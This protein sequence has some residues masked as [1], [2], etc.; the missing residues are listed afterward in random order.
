MK[1]VNLVV[2]AQGFI[3]VPDSFLPSFEAQLSERDERLDSVKRH[4]AQSVIDLVQDLQAHGATDPSIFEGF[5]FSFR[6]PQISSEFDLLKITASHVVNIELKIEDVG[7]ERIEHQLA[8]NR[9]Y[10]APLERTT[11]TFTYV[12]N[13]GTLFELQDNGTFEQASMGRLATLLAS[14][15]E[16]YLDRVEDLFKA[17]NYLV[18]PLNDTDRFLEGSYF[19]TN[20]QEQIKAS[21]VTAC[22]SAR[23]GEPVVYL[24]YGSTGT[25]KSLLLYDL[26]RSLSMPRQ[27]GVIH[28]GVL[29]GGHELLN[30]RQDLFHVLSAKGLEHV[31][32]EGYG[33]L[34]VDEAQ[35]LWPSQLRR[36][37]ATAVEHCI[38]LYLSFDRRYITS[39]AGD[40]RDAEQ[41][42]RETC[43]NVSIWELSR[44]IRTNRE[45]A[46]FLRA[47]SNASGH[48]KVVNTRKV[49]V[50]YAAS[51]SGVHDL[52]DTYRSEGYQ[53]IAYADPTARESSFDVIR[54]TGC[55]SVAEVVGQ[56]F[57]KV[58]MVM[59]KTYSSEDGSLYRQLL[60]QGLTRARD[61]IALVVY[62]DE[63]L[64]SKL[65]SIL[66][67]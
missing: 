32:L 11:H 18:S 12:A 56:E 23:D 62:G 17:S 39:R 60:L 27:I 1:P 50:S 35:R 33:A 40:D 54:V 49:K 31:A 7:G 38:P 64:L 14:L 52:V 51:V 24:V 36:I 13:T 61:C 29:S 19:L 9:Y 15:D 67:A 47:L 16:P 46:S 5:S 28:C 58:V 20:H 44:K 30:S 25:G 26:A 59:D 65:L 48:P 41:I 42:V 10:L 6:I 37:V 63:Q 2:L 21:F 4:E 22:A 45:L 55:P 53:Y 66:N 34:L 3:S 8:R 57:D 43:P